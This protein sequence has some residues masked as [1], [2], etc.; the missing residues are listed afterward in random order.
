MAS[1]NIA[2]ILGNILTWALPSYGSLLKEQVSHSE[3]ASIKISSEV[4]ADQIILLP[5]VS[6]NYQF[7]VILRVE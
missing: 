1:R 5:I 2:G 7:G 4:D 3:I 6:V